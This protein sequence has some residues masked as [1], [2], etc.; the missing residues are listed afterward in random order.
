VGRTT[1]IALL[2]DRHSLTVLVACAAAALSS[3]SS[4]STRIGK[5][6]SAGVEA[7]LGRATG[8]HFTD[9]GWQVID[10][11]SV[12]VHRIPQVTIGTD[13]APSDH[14]APAISL[15]ATAE[16]VADRCGPGTGWHVFD[17]PRRRTGH[18]F[19]RCAPETGDSL[20]W[21]KVPRFDDTRATMLACPALEGVPFENRLNAI[22]DESRARGGEASVA[23][24]L[25]A[26]LA[27]PV[28]GVTEKGR[29]DWDLAWGKLPDANRASIVAERRGKASRLGRRRGGPAEWTRHTLYEIDV[30]NGTL[31]QALHWVMRSAKETMSRPA[32]VR[33][34]ALVHRGS[35]RAGGPYRRSRW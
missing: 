10:G 32:H 25:K 3:C 30:T 11:I 6:S 19:R 8:K 31:V 18:A 24:Y 1:A 12:I 23:A 14:P 34:R 33:L 35:E 2:V 15:D 22:V 26:M 5:V 4:K 16:R 28:L 17:V 9:R 13:C 20:D 21:L 7:E 27:Q 29:D